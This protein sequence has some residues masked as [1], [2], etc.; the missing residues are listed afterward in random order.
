MAF[1]V[2]LNAGRFC[3]EF[4]VTPATHAFVG[5]TIGKFLR[6]PLLALTA[7][8]ASHAILDCLPHRDSWYPE[9]QLVYGSLTVA[10]L[11]WALN[12][13]NRAA[14]F[15]G[16][17]GALLPDV[18]HIPRHNEEAPRTKRLFPSHWF[19][20][21]DRSGR[22]GVAIELLV[23]AITLAFCLKHSQSKTS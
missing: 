7:G 1:R 22:H 18:E 9:W 21:E 4:R 2:K 10:I 20:H 16:A 3:E 8:V 13:P 14:N 19:R 5:M 6:K 23:V 17:I 11:A 15:A 12:S